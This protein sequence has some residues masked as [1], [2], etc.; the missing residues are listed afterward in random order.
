[1]CEWLFL[2]KH[3]DFRVM[4]L[5]CGDQRV[6]LGPGRLQEGVG[7]VGVVGSW[8]ARGPGRLFAQVCVSVPRHGRVV[9]STLLHAESARP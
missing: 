7:P 2:S 6:H 8:P 5:S 1:M 9:V 3:T 4:A